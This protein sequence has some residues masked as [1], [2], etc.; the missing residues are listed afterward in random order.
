MIDSAPPKKLFSKNVKEC[1]DKTGIIWYYT[2]VLRDKVIH[3][4]RVT[5]VRSPKSKR[6][7][8]C[9]IIRCG[10]HQR[11]PGPAEIWRGKTFFKK[12]ERMY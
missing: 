5:G 11:T 12:C 8:V 3:H 7:A 9:E 2:I 4:L 1:I 10:S 6:R